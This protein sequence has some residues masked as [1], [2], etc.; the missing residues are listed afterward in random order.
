MTEADC[1]YGG[2]TRPGFDSSANC[3]TSFVVFDVPGKDDA[4]LAQRT[5]EF[6]IEAFVPQLVVVALD[7][8][9]LPKTA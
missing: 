7:V 9:V 8:S 5:K 6:P 2:R 1:C 4:G 3:R